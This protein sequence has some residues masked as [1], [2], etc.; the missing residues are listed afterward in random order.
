MRPNA[1]SDQWLGKTY[2]GFRQAHIEGNIPRVCQG[3]YE[4]EKS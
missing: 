2:Q 3:C 4:R 1:F